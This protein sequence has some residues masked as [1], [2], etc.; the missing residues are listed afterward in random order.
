MQTICSNAADLL[1]PVCILQIFKLKQKFK[2]QYN[3]HNLAEL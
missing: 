2:E 3:D 1:F